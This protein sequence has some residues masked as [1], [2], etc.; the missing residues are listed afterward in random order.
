MSKFIG[1]E[2]GYALLLT[3]LISSLFSILA[4]TLLMATY[5]GATRT[6]LRQDVHQSNQ[7]AEK[8][9][10]HISHKITSILEKEIEENSGLPEQV[11]IQRLNQLLNQYLCSNP[12]GSKI[13]VDT[14]TGSYES[15]ITDIRPE[16]NA[17][18]EENPYRKIVTFRSIGYA[19]GKRQ[20]VTFTMKIG[21]NS[22]PDALNYALGSHILCTKQSDCIKG[23]GNMFLHGGIEVYGDIKVDGHLITADRGR[24]YMGGRDYWVESLYPAIKPLPDS[25]AKNAKI[26]L[27]KELYS[28]KS[29]EIALNDGKDFGYSNHIVRENFNDSKKYVK[30]TNNIQEAFHSSGVPRVVIR[31]PIIDPVSITEL[32]NNFRYTSSSP[33]VT[34]VSPKNGIFNNVNYSNKK[35]YS[36]DKTQN[37][38]FTG[39]NTF[40]SFSTDQTIYI[41]GNN[42]KTTIENTMYVG[43][44]L[45]IGNQNINSHD[46]PV[47]Q[48][49]KIQLSGTI[50]VDGDL[51]IRGVNAQFN[52][53]IYVTGN[54]D[55][56]Y[57]VINGL[58]T[59]DGKEGSLIIFAEGDIHIAN[60]SV[61]QNE[62]SNIKGF[63]Y[64]KKAFEMYGVGSN[65]KINGGISAR[66]IVLNAIR[67]EAR[68]SCSSNCQQYNK[69]NNEYYTKGSYQTNKP[70]RLQIIYNPEIIKTYSDLK[71]NEPI[72][73]KVDLPEII[74]RSLE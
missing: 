58:P 42:N 22:V 9:A 14:E 40:G 39:N 28:I 8:G 29:S 1:N 10:R 45:Y 46:T 18:G 12:N 27:G 25:K 33:N 59:K 48:Y 70:S 11:F 24:M 56:Q 66:R 37:Y 65:V 60:N 74:R 20:E 71:K 63:F 72:V 51:Y 26:V 4:M 61:Y 52:A 54:V 69:Y 64:S 49:D 62:P 17:D 43:K 38:K 2:K 6:E 7:L 32:K 16:I 15:C 3:I 30:R 13:K 73:E 68:Q 34:V 31:N 35:V 47:S 50:F 19:D 5:T 53:L 67:G 23:E 55:I 41:S 57:S 21:S 44:N 36:N